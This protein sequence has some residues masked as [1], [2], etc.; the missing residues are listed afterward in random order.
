[1]DQLLAE[2][3]EPEYRRCCDRPGQSR[4]ILCATGEGN[5]SNASYPGSGIYLSDD[6]G[7]T[8]RSFI[9]IPGQRRISPEDRDRMPR[10]VASISF[11]AQN[12]ELGQRGLAF[13]SISNDEQLIGDCI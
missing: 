10:R 12:P 1:M 8:W 11:S 7:F 5:I 6:G 13:G 9:F 4:S 3:V 2:R